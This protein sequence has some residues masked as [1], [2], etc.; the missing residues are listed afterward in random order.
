MR[1]LRFVNQKLLFFLPLS[2]VG[3]VERMISIPRQRTLPFSITCYFYSLSER[4]GHSF[5]RSHFRRCSSFP[6]FLRHVPV[7]GKH[8]PLDERWVFSAIVLLPSRIRGS[9][10]ICVYRLL[11][12]RPILVNFRYRVPATFGTFRPRIDPC[13]RFNKQYDSWFLICI[14]RW[15]HTKYVH[16][17]AAPQGAHFLRNSLSSNVLHKKD[18]TATDTS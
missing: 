13:S 2:P 16:V 14:M 1:R 12:T 3:C 10:N 5:S 8:M 17:A 7:Q 11:I 18:C 6:R 15:E 4:C 9:K